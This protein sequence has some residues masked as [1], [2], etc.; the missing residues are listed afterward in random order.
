MI[1]LKKISLLF[2]VFVISM[3]AMQIFAQTEENEPDTVLMKLEE[4]LKKTNL[5]WEDLE[6]IV[7]EREVANMMEQRIEEKGVGVYGLVQKE[8][9]KYAQKLLESYGISPD[10]SDSVYMLVYTPKS[11]TFGM[12]KHIPIRKVDAL[13]V[14]G[15]ILHRGSLFLSPNVSKSSWAYAY[16]KD[17]HYVSIVATEA[18]TGTDIIVS[19]TR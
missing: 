1:C 4:V 9:K 10:L 8:E 5:T 3:I 13:C 6:N 19:V 18:Q 16:E 12:T 14:P 11:F 15:T 17:G 2:C 7:K